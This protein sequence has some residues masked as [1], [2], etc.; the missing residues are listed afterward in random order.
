MFDDVLRFWLDRGVDGF[1]VDV[2]HGLFKDRRP[3]RPEVAERRP[4]S[5][6]AGT[7]MVETRHQAT[8][9][10]G[11]SPRCTRSTARWHKVLDEYD[12]DRMAVAEAWTATPEAMAALRPP[13]RAAARRSTSPGCWPSGTPT[14]IRRG[15][16]PAPSRPSTRSAPH[17][18]W[19]LSATTTWSGTPRGTAA[20]RSAWPAPARR[21]WRCW[22]CPGRRTSTRARSSASRGRRRARGLRQDPAWFRTGERV[23]RR[24]PGADAVGRHASRRSGSGRAR[25]AV[26]PAAGRLGR[27]HG[28]G[29]D[30]QTRARRWRSTARRWRSGVPSPTTAPRDVEILDRARPCWRSRRGP[31]TVVLNCRPPAGLAAGGQG[32]GHQRPARRRQAAAGHRGL[33]VGSGQASSARL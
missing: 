9:R 25:A 2:A 8:S 11:T 7:S 22:R 10:C 19:V 33:A 16:S 14:D 12:G 24:L 4:S 5:R 1:R 18:T 13:R 26:D 23:A 6:R 29:P 30:R 31:V 17:P 28:R 27:P 20:A 3:A 32:A 15:A 21:R